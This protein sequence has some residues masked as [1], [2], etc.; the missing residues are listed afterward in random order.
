MQQKNME[1]NTILLCKDADL[2]LWGKLKLFLPFTLIEMKKS[3][4]GILANLY[5]QTKAI[6]IFLHR[7][8][9]P[10]NLDI[11]N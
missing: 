11:V 8:V 1:N 6:Q 10:N 3:N 9:D 7:F 5:K 2:K 4:T